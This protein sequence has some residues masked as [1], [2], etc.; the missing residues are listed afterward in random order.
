MTSITAE[1]TGRLIG[2]ARVSTAAQDE[3]LQLAALRASGVAPRDTYTDHGVSGS[4]TS[5]PQ[6][7][8]MLSHVEAG[9]TVVVWKLDRLGRNSGHVITVIDNLVKR[10]VNVRTLDGVDTTTS[11]GKAMLGMLAVFA[12]MER[13]FIQERTKAGLAVAKTEG[14]TGGRPKALDSK[15]AKLAQRL[16]DDGE[17]VKEIAETL[18]VGVATIY[19]YLKK[20]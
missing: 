17:P 4:K 6:L 3:E 16:Y 15:K 20:A 1:A 8:A 18:H 2:Y 10:G 7:D 14:R 11:T 19:R 5:R 12:E 9:D 13:G